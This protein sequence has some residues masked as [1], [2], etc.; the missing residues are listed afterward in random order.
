MLYGRP[1]AGEFGF[2]L[3][4]FHY[5]KA[6]AKGLYKIDKAVLKNKLVQRAATTAANAYA[7]GSGSLVQAGLTTVS[8]GGGTTAAPAGQPAA[9]PQV[10]TA[11]DSTDTDAAAPSSHGGGAQ[12]F[13]MPKKYVLIGGGILGAVLLLKVL[14]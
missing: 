3:N 4:P 8:S 2:S 11:A 14:R 7:P 9:P 6:G 10:P 1:V 13:G 5:V 12:L